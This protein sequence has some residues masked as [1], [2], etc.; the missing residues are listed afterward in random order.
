MSARIE[1]SS[2]SGVVALGDATV[3]W[4]AGLEQEILLRR[5]EP[6]AR[7]AQVFF[8]MTDDPVKYRIEV[9]ANEPLPSGLDREFESFGGAFRLEAPNERVAL[10]GWDKSE[11]MD[12]ARRIRTLAISELPDQDCCT[13]L[14]PRQVETR[15]RLDDLHRIEGRLDVDGLAGELARSAQ[16]Y[17]QENP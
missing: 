8:L 16:E 3:A 1:V 10:I 12:E 4:P 2:E 5:L 14:A 7:S 17:R 11:I 9:L 15:A 13:L 6:L